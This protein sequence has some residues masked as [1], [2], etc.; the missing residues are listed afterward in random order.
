MTVDEAL[1]SADVYARYY[2]RDKKMPNG[3]PGTHQSMTAMTL[4]AEV[5]R[6]RAELEVVTAEMVRAR[7]GNSYA[8]QMD[9][10]RDDL[11]AM[12]EAW[13]SED[14]SA[15]NA[16]ADRVLGKAGGQ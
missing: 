3:W 1:K 10:Y 16:I 6:L 15:C 7:D 13:Q 5:R 11:R 12:C 14:A 4:A 9:C 8:Q 2:E